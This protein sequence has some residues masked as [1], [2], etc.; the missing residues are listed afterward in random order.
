MNSK[1]K[2]G[3]VNWQS[4][5]SLA[6]L[7]IASL[8]VLK[9]AFFTWFGSKTEQCKTWLKQVPRD[10]KR[11]I[12]IQENTYVHTRSLF[13][14]NLFIE[15]EW[16]WIKNKITFSLCFQI[17]LRLFQKPNALVGASFMDLSTHFLFA[18]YFE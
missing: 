1:L 14:N 8:T 13:I 18:L 17:S 6:S 7:R 2:T 16:L 3:E 12:N 5:T 9:T 11:T 15:T 10:P 4:E